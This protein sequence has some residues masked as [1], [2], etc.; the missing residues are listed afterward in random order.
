M[1]V[2][3][4]TQINPTGERG[5]EVVS[6]ILPKAKHVDKDGYDFVLPN[7][8]LLEVKAHYGNSGLVKFK[9]QSKHARKA[10]TGVWQNDA[11]HHLLIVTKTHLL[12]ID[13]RQFRDFIK[14]NQHTVLNPGKVMTVSYHIDDIASR[15][16]VVKYARE[17]LKDRVKS[18]EFLNGYFGT[19]VA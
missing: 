9:I 10:G 16:W 13:A 2:E 4:R 8:K 14:S 3:R 11:A 15:P 6:K 12:F 7:Q 18:A 5:E 17:D 1:A 19:A